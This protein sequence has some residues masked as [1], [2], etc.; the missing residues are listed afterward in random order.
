[1]PSPPLTLIRS[2]PPRWSASSLQKN[3]AEINA[4]NK[5]YEIFY[6][7]ECF[8]MDQREEMK[9]WLAILLQNSTKAD[10]KIVHQDI[11]MLLNVT[12][13]LAGILSSRVETL[14]RQVR[15][16]PR[17]PQPQQL[18]PPSPD[19]SKSKSKQTSTP[20]P[21]PTTTTEPKSTKSAQKPVQRDLQ[22][23]QRSSVTSKTNA[24]VASNAEE[25]LELT[26]LK[27]IIHQ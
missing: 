21:T 23:P 3:T 13:Q 26:S 20:S 1:M 8:F 11:D 24:P 6:V 27:P 17:A 7:C 25:P 5:R 14:H 16:A 10:A 18:E 9:R 4:I 2:T 19:H 15:T 12:S 22:K